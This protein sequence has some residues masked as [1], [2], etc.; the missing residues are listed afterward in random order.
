MASTKSEIED[1]FKG[2]F[3]P[4]GEP[5]MTRQI[6][7]IQKCGNDNIDGWIPQKTGYTLRTELSGS[8]TQGYLTEQL[9][10]GDWEG[11]LAYTSGMLKFE[12][13]RNGSFRLVNSNKDVGR[14]PF[15]GDGVE[16]Y[17]DEWALEATNAD[18]FKPKDKLEQGDLI[19]AI[20]TWKSEIDTS[21][22]KLVTR[23]G[24]SKYC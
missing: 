15:I 10:D 7:K 1:K 21:E 9:H 3:A 16:W 14:Y 18:D 11:M 8:D 17:I 4:Q 12:P 13:A 2:F 23:Y 5:N 20:I 24:W 6:I 19:C 22:V